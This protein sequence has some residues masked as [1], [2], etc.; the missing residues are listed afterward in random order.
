MSKK[1]T[2]TILIEIPLAMYNKLQG[3][4]RGAISRLLRTY[5]QDLMDGCV[6]EKIHPKNIAKSKIEKLEKDLLDLKENF[7]YKNTT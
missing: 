4:N 6:F 3:D 2:K 7:D 1:Q 5:L